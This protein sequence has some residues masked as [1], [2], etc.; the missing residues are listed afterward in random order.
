MVDKVDHIGIAVNSL[1]EARKFYEDVLGLKCQRV[2]E[3]ETQKVR[4]AF[5][6]LGD[7]TIELLEPTSEGSPVAKFLSKNG[8]GVHHIAFYSQDVQSQLNQ[9]QECGCKLINKEPVP[10]A[11]GKKIAFLHPGSTHG[12]LT[13]LCCKEK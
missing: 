3:I 10:G 5:F 9:A 6:P 2:E 7:L 13:E 1:E 12:V 4:T 11:G 8:E